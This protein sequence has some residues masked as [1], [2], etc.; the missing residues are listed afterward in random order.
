MIGVD[1]EMPSLFHNTALGRAESDNL[2]L[3]MLDGIHRRGNTV[4]KM[5]GSAQD[6]SDHQIATLGQWLVTRYGNPAATVT[7]AQVAR[8]RQG[9]RSHLVPIVQAATGAGAVI[10]VTIVALWWRRRN[11]AIT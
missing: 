3:V 4:L 11:R 5:P 6:M 9:E 1:H 8:L 10:A 7:D 2:V